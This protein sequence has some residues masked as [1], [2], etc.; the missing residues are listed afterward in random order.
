M[1]AI[2][3]YSNTPVAVSSRTHTASKLV[4]GRNTIAHVART[5]ET[6]QATSQRST[7]QADAQL[8]KALVRNRFARFTR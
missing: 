2:R 4:A 8:A 1:A 6:P 3:S 5:A 7:A